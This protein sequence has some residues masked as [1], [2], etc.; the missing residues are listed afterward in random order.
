[1]HALKYLAG[2]VCPTGK[3]RIHLVHILPPLPA[4]LLEHGGAANPAEE[5]LLEADLFGQQRDCISAAKKAAEKGLKEAKS[6]LENAGATKGSVRALFCETGEKQDVADSIL[7]MAREYGCHTIVV[8]RESVSW[9]HE[10]FSQELA[11]ELLRRGKGF[12][13]W[14]IE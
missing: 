2:F 14:V 7:K 3:F 6:A 12:S 4:M 8:G 11:E 10:L 9:F 5:P 1:M 13:I